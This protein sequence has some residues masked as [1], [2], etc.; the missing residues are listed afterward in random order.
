MKVALLNLVESQ[1]SR[2]RQEIGLGDTEAIN[3]KS[4]LLKLNVLTIYRP[5]SEKFSGMS[6]KSGEQRFMLVNSNQPKCR[7]HFTIAHELYHLFIDPN[8]MPHNCSAE[9]KKN[10]AEQCADAFAQ[11]FLMPADGVRQMIPDNELIS[12]HVSLASVLR[13][14]HYFSVSHAAVLNRLFDLKLIDRKERDCY[15]QYPV[16]KTAKEYG[17]GTALYEPGNENLVI[18]NFGEKARKLFEEEK[19]SEGH[20]ME[21]LHKIGI[22][23]SED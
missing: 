8:P 23:D 10:D 22:N 17:Y 14:E 16:K 21:L 20:Y 1:V 12:G 11:I 6:L 13:I 19:I 5:L 2:F 18:G 4:L 3:L 9:G 15:L 7:Q